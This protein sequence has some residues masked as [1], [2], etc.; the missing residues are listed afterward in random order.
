MHMY[1]EYNHYQTRIKTSD[2][3]D[4]PG[5]GSTRWISVSPKYY[6]VLCT[7]F[8]DRHLC[9]DIQSFIISKQED[10]KLIIL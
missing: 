10:C 6:C 9:S 2:N 7:L 1:M 8:F 3:V 4:Y 5:N